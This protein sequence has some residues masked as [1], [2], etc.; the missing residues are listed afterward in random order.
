MCTELLAKR[1]PIFKPPFVYLLVR[2][3]RNKM[4]RAM[5]AIS[6][7]TRLFWCLFMWGGDLSLPE[8][9]LKQRGDLLSPHGQ[10]WHCSKTCLQRNL[11]QNYVLWWVNGTELLSRA[12]VFG[13]TGEGFSQVHP[14]VCSVRMMEEAPA[15]RGGLTFNWLAAI[16]FGQTWKWYSL[17]IVKGCIVAE[18][19]MP[20]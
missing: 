16:W 20:V 4:K 2:T 17:W 1:C 13:I 19:A 8:R 9:T 18:C 12:G 3:R 5:S 7:Q 6:N 11:G 10:I 14:K 15:N